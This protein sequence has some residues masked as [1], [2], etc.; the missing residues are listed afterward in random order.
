MSCLDLLAK[1][2]AEHNS[3]YQNI[4][5]TRELTYLPYAT[6]QEIRDYL[7]LKA[8][9]L[10]Q[11]Q[12]FILSFTKLN[13]LLQLWESRKALNHCKGCHITVEDACMCPE[14]P[15]ASRCECIATLSAPPAAVSPVSLVSEEMAALLPE[16]DRTTVAPLFAA[17]AVPPTT[18]GQLPK[19][20]ETALATIVPDHVSRETWKSACPGTKLNLQV[21]RVDN[22]TGYMEVSMTAPLAESDA[23]A[24]FVPAVPPA[25]H[26]P[27]P[28]P[29]EMVLAKMIKIDEYG[30]YVELPFYGRRE[31]LVSPFEVPR[32]GYKGRDAWK[33]AFTAGKELN[34]R[35]LRVDTTTGYM[36]ASMCR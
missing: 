16:P 2:F 1:K 30:I 17:P 9:L 32:G 14:C 5:G 4:L 8:G 23:P 34:V 31:A 36:D 27:L 12:P 13:Q 33:L 24:P 18:L 15:H 28:Q 11:L 19:V 25:T 6:D 35:V 21:L 29:G 10:S 7:A 20:G 26:G 22:T 3:R